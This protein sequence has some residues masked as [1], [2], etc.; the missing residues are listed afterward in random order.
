MIREAE[1]TAAQ[2][3][4]KVNERLA[5]ILYGRGTPVEDIADILEISAEEIRQWIGLTQV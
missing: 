5:Q 3:T 1:E 4:Q 2:E